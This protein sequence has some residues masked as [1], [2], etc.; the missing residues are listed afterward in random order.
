[1]KQE[2]AAAALEAERLNDAITLPQLRNSYRE[3]GLPNAEQY[4]RIVE[5]AFLSPLQQPL[6]TFSIDVDTASY[7]N[8]RRF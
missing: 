2:L 6:S 1:M 3:D 5:N 8:M 4:D 7:A